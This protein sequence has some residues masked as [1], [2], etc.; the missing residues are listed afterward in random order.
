MLFLLILSVV[1]GA[2][3]AILTGMGFLFWVVAI[4]A[5]IFGLPGL[6]IYGFLEGIGDHIQGR[7]EYEDFIR[8]L[9][10]DRRREEYLDRLEEINNKPN[11]IIDN[12]QIHYHYH[13]DSDKP[14]KKSVG[15]NEKT[16]KR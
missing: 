11:I 16:L 1:I 15:K 14:A 6:I 7:D 12:R 13:T 10:E 2:I 3:V 8:D 4:A 5:F 9:D